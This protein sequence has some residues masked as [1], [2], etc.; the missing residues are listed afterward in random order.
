MHYWSVTG[1]LFLAYWASVF[2]PPLHAPVRP[3]GSSGNT[4]DLQVDAGPDTN[5]CYP[6]GS[7]GLM[8]SITGDDVFYQWTPASGLSNP[9][10]LTP[11]ANVNADITYTLTAYAID[12]NSPELV[13]N[14]DFSAGNTGFSS[15][16]TYV[17]DLP[18]VQNEMVPEGTYTVITN[19]NLVHTGFSPCTDHT[20]G[21]GNMMVVNGAANLQDIWC[22]TVSVTPGALYN[23]SAWVASVNPASPAQLQFSINGIPIGNIVNAVSTPCVWIP[24]NAI[25]NAGSNT[26]A[27]ICILNLN[28][29]AGGNDFALDDISM[30][31]LCSV[32]DEVEITLY[33]EEA[34]DAEFMGPDVVCAGDIATYT[35]DF[36]PDPLIYTYHWN[37]PQGATLLNGQGTPEV[38]ILW[39]EDQETSLCLDIETRCDIN[40]SCYAITVNTV[41]DLPQIQ[42][43]TQLC[44]GETAIFYTPEQ[45]FDDT[46]DWIVPPNV[47]IIN[48]DGTN[49]IEIAW[50]SAGEAEICVAVTN[51][52]GTTDNCALITLSPAYLTL[53]DT[54]IC[55]GTTFDLNG[56]TYGNGVLSGIEYFQTVEGC[57]SVVEVEVMEVASL[58]YM[59]TTHLCPG[60]SIFLAG[61]FQ[62]EAGTYIDTFQTV[63]GCDSIILTEVLITPFD[64]TWLFSHT[65][66]AAQSGLFVTTYSLGQCDSTVITQVDFIPADTTWQISYSCQAAD[67]MSG[68]LLLTNRFGC[69]SIVI[70]AIR[71]LASDTTV[72]QQTSCDPADVGTDT[73]ALSNLSGCDSLVILHTT[74][75]L[76]DTTRLDQYVCTYA[77]TGTLTNLWTNQQ[78]C[79]S[80]VIL[81]SLYGGTDT[82]YVSGT[83]CM[84]VDSGWTF[85]QT[86]NRFGCDSVTAFYQQWI[87][88]DT[89][90]LRAA[91]CSPADT[92]TVIQHLLNVGGCDSTIY[93]ITTLRDPD[94]CFL[95]VDY[96]W[97]LPLCYGDPAIV[98]IAITTGLGPFQLDIVHQNITDSHI[99]ADKG[100]YQVPLFYEGFAMLILRSA[101]GLVTHDSVDLLFPPPLMVQARVSSDYHGYGIAC[102]GDSTGM[103]TVSVL[104]AG[105]PPLTYAWSNGASGFSIDGLP[106]GRYSITVTDGNGC[107][108]SDS[109]TIQSPPS[110]QWTVQARDIRCFGR[111]DGEILVDA[112][113]GG[114][115]PYL[116]SLDGS[117]FSM[118]VLHT[119]LGPGWHE[120]ILSDQNGCSAKTD[121]LIE[122]PEAWQID[123][124]P[125]TTVRYGTAL[126]LHP[127]LLGTPQGPLS[128]HWSDGECPDCFDRMITAISRIQLIMEVTDQN[129][130]TDQDDIIIQARLDR[131][132]FIPNV[133]SPNGDQINDVVLISA[134]EDLQKIASFRIFDR[135]GNLVFSAYDFPANSPADSWDGRWNGQLLNPAVFTYQLI[136]VYVDGRKEVRF[137]DITL[138]R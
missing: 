37:I 102:A 69:D 48:G 5:V 128:I 52:C 63:A 14:G 88:A 56:H 85:E 127:A 1:I 136:A 123:L 20:S 38:T 87:P 79:D 101:N 24:F 107:Q 57:D 122:E 41:P 46:Y 75:L 114:L 113:S 110:L 126:L 32:S 40:T 31:G 138:V 134:G 103:A 81:T 74:F 26:T 76:S 116:I 80:L 34:P 109:V 39:T 21:S 100:S 98:Q 83:T 131:N 106:A 7:V 17:V 55:A 72:L 54:M 68:I 115:S 10:I 50:V 133:F 12:P 51:D 61:A 65:C 47:S 66:D 112:I 49:E 3:I 90:T 58:E 108:E 99:F 28:T 82:V 30:K 62:E 129:G 117:V 4:C 70:I 59:V 44:P 29:A 111:E 119:G 91:A 92:G 6:G 13:I 43:T 8:G 22:Q 120:V 105:T 73:I 118:E 35:A 27:Q 77:D 53:F 96:T 33:E 93:R 84:A 36:P 137:G 64:T 121:I 94:S 25:W 71:L 86:M 104:S 9:F 16:Y 125:D 2:H 23:I 78:G 15:D 132:L 97:Q 45:A 60:D 95:M 18:A 42:G 135:W 67:T 130:C 124:G 89:T 19:P 11:V